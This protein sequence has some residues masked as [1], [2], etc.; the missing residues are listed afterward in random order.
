MLNVH[1]RMSQIKFLAVPETVYVWVFIV[2]CS[3]RN[4]IENRAYEELVCSSLNIP[5]AIILPTHYLSQSLYTYTLS[6]N[7]SLSLSFSLSLSL[8]TNTHTL[9]ILCT[10]KLY[11]SLHTLSL[12]LSIYTL[13]ISVS[14]S[15]HTLSLSI[16]LSVA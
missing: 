14:L 8:S 5:L 6:L 12:Y 2:P 16:C 10:S 11:I 7:L 4:F 1:Y 9:S 15:M 13:S 3:S